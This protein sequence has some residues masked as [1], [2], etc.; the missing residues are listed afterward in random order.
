MEPERRGVDVSIG[1]Q[2]VFHCRVGWTVGKA[3]EEIYLA[4]K[5]SGG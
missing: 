5:I 3:R 2:N 4:R 1:G